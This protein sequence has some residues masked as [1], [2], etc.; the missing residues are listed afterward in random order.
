MG[1]SESSLSAVT[2]LLALPFSLTKTAC[3]GG[4]IVISDGPLKYWEA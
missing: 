3:F 4:E 2:L 1:N